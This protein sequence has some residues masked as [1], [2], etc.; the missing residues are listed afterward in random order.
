MYEIGYA[1][2]RDC[3]GKG[4]ATD[5]AGR[6]VEFA[7]DELKVKHLFATHASDNV[8]SGKVIEKIGFTYQNE[9]AYSSFD[10]SRTFQSKEYFMNLI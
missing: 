9:G 8:A 3:W 6:I 2:A 7:K 4:L 5:A 10:G 1:L